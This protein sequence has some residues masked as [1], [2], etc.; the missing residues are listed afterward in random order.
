MNT[1]IS[2]LY[3]D[4]CNYKKF[5]D[6]IVSGQL[7]PNDLFSCLKDKEFFVPSEVGLMDLQEDVFTQ[8]D[9]IWHALC[10]VEAT[11]EPENIPITASELKNAF[12]DAYANGWNEYSVYIKKGL[13]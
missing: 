13:I 12:R 8:Y 7:E 3:R 9:H 6:V 11:D 2:Y 10:S 4:A 5:H 1:I